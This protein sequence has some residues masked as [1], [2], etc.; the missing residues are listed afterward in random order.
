MSVDAI[1]GG[2]VVAPGFEPVA[3]AFAAL[4]AERPE[5]GAALC[6]YVDGAPVVDLWGGP[7]YGRDAAQVVFS[8]TKGVTAIC[9]AMLVQEG[10]LDPGAP[11][12]EYWPEFA[13]AGKQAVTVAQLMSHRAGLPAV[14]G[15]FSAAEWGD[16]TVAGALARQAPLWPPGTVLAYHAITYGALADALVRRVTGL[17]VGQLVAERLAGPLGLD[18]WIGMPPELAGRVVP[19]VA[20]PPAEPP[21]APGTLGRR[22]APPPF[23]LSEDPTLFNDPALRAVELPAVNGVASAR[24]LARLYAACVSD[25]DGVR[26]LTPET[27]ARVSTT[28]SHG[29][30]AIQEKEGRFGLGFMLPIERVPMAGAGSFGHDGFG[31]SIAFGHP[32][33][34]LAVGF[35]TDLISPQRGADPATPGLVATLLRCLG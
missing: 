4:L 3:E 20:D 5:N 24:A 8:S 23:D 13:A 29:I 35:T 30:D 11:V 27:V 26:L 12:A 9:V 25:V 1:G 10:L 16:G 7:T 21:P 31:G 14:D 28:L 34:G 19:L 22:L 6:A 32:P 33:L 17:T 15:S 18:L 2:Q